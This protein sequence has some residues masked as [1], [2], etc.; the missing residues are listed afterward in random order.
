MK[1][2]A[3]LKKLLE[4]R[5]SLPKELEKWINHNLLITFFG[6]STDTLKNWRRNRKVEFTR[7]SGILLYNWED[8]VL[9]LE[10]NKVPRK[11]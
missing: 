6:I 9:V 10:K 5:S 11:K 2:E 8:I 3:A 1:S 4:Q 7:F